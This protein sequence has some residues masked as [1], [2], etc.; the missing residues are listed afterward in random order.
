MSSA[1]RP[2]TLDPVLNLAKRRGFIYQTASLYGGA[3]GL[4]DYGP[5]GVEL[6][7]AI[8]QAWWRRFVY[9]RTDVVGVDTSILTP[10]AVLKASGHVDSFSD[11]L[12]ECSKCMVRL[13]ADHFSREEDE[14]SFVGRWAQER[15]KYQKR[16]ELVAKDKEKAAEAY[17]RLHQGS[18][19]AY[20]Q[21]LICPS[22]GE[23]GCFGEPREFNM[24]FQT[25]LG[26]VADEGAVA[27]LRPETAQG[28]FVNFA[29]ILDTS[30][31]KL[32]FGIAQ[33][34]KAFRNEITVGNSLFRVR[35]L[36]Q[37]EIEFFVKPG[38]DEQWHEQWIQAWQA[39]VAEDLQ[40]GGDLT[41]LYEHPKEKLSHYS[42][43]TV[44]IEYQFPAMGWGELAGIAN[45][46]DFDLKQHAEH[47]GQ[48]LDYFEEATRERFVPFVIEPTIGVGRSA[49]AVL[50]NSYREYPEGRDGGGE[51]EMVLHL[52]KYLAPVRAAVLPLMKKD[53]LAEKAQEIHRSLL[54]RDFTVQYDE[55]GAVGRRYRRQDEIGTPYCI[56]IDHQTLEDGTVTIR[57]RDTME[58]QRVKVEEI[59]SVIG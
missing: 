1:E 27:Y 59:L 21:D 50:A 12:I 43:R 37:M 40:L 14:V 54:G 47:S 52:P 58:Q 48:A 15:A 41:R 2:T 11:P 51:A 5:L 34:G 22:C 9:G 18:G 16:S 26:A 10:A 36:E 39:F 20:W 17:V 46:T 31:V 53:G 7:R 24:M 55:S 13:R 3:G 38:E 49:L 57:D 29:N 32:P 4:F 33:I 28:M 44:D 23:V 35:E 30:R 56:T 6:V 19:E 45:R 25:N 8:K 42:K